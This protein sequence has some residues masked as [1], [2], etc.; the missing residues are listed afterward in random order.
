M[1]GLGQS[2]VTGCQTWV[3]PLRDTP[4][5]PLP[6]SYLWH[7]CV[8]FVPRC[9]GGGAGQKVGILLCHL[10]GPGILPFSLP[11]YLS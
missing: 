11:V 3:H 7:L 2:H 1:G 9:W 10:V 6:W 4:Q 5:L 8:A